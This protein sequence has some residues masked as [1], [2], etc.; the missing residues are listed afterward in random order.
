MQLRVL[1]PGLNERVLQLY[2][3]WPSESPDLNPIEHLWEIMK[4][5]LEKK[6][7]KNM[8]ELKEAIFETWESITSNTTGSL[9]FIIIAKT[10]RC[11]NRCPWWEYQ[12]LDLQ[13]EIEKIITCIGLY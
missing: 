11:C 13:T 1:C 5:R 3:P 7:C 4:K 8:D 10:L 12:V 9:V 6:P 2:S